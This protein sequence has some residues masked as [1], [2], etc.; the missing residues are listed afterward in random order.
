VPL[1]FVYVIVAAV[2][3]LLVWQWR[4]R[5]AGMAK[6][7]DKTLGAMTQRMGLAVEAGDPSVNLLYFQ[8]PS[9][10]YHREL[11]ASGQPYGRPVTFMLTDGTKISEY[12]VVRKITM[13]FGCCLEARVAVGL[14][15]FEVV[16]RT[17]NEYL[18]PH[19]EMTERGM[20]EVRTGRA[21]LDGT[22]V[23]RA[24]DPRVGPA[25]VPAL[26]ALVG[27][28]FVHL[29]GEGGAVWMSFTRWGLPY[30]S[31]APEEY[32]L[33]L[34]SAACAFEGRP[35]PARLAPA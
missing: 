13:S 35:A 25:L 16:L 3:G 7:S 30:L 9:G 29:A 21:D 1:P 24:A 27:Q 31:Y 32:L 8:H 23:V 17:P 11:R 4:A 26:E 22:F 18:I 15:P 20:P 6:H 5:A 10:Q 19:Q 14:P 2:L 34:E 28:Q 33:A 12:I